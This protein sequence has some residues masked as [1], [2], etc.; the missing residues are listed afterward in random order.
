MAISSVGA[1]AATALAAALALGLAETTASFGLGTL[2]A[3]L[4]AGVLPGLRIEQMEPVRGR[5]HG[6]TGGAAAPAG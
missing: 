6:H 4:L 5:L 2:G 1:D 3:L